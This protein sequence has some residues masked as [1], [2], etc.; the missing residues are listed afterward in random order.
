MANATL[1]ALRSRV[2]TRAEH[3]RNPTFVDQLVNEALQEASNEFDWPWLITRRAPIT[4]GDTI[5]TGTTY[6][7]PTA[8]N[9]ADADRAVILAVYVDDHEIPQR[10]ALDDEFSRD[11][12]TR[13]WAIGGDGSDPDVDGAVG[14]VTITIRPSVETTDTVEVSW[15]RLE[16]ILTDDADTTVCPATFAYGP[17]VTLAVA[18]AYLAHPDEANAHVFH[19]R[20]YRRQ[21]N[22]YSVDVRPS[23]GPILPRTRAG[24]RLIE[25]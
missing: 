24:R 11:L 9:L 16:N 25:S 15:K 5:T 18:K 20:E 3:A 21:I 22:A 7:F 4:D 8:A 14:N 17:V 12:R 1:S 13:S 19:M 23:R 6:S 2:Q 10:S